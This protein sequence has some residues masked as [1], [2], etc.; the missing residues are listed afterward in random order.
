MTEEQL[1]RFRREV[2]GGFGL[3]GGGARLEVRVGHAS[4]LCGVRVPPVSR[5]VRLVR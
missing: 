1:D 5:D 2:G 3:S 4:A